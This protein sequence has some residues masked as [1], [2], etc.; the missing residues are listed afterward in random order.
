MNSKEAIN[1]LDDI[2]E[3][4]NDLDDIINS[5]PDRLINETQRESFGVRG[6]ITTYS[7]LCCKV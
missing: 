1:D 4:N 6:N 5:Q 7:G 3:A 2:I